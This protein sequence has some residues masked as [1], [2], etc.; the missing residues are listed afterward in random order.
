[1]M[2][3]RCVCDNVCMLQEGPGVGLP[4]PSAFP[5]AVFARENFHG[6]SSPCYGIA[7]FGYAISRAN[8][9]PRGISGWI[10]RIGGFRGYFEGKSEGQYAIAF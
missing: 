1:M 7:V 2:V 10:C 6:M 3:C 5:S 9:S 8:G 4:G